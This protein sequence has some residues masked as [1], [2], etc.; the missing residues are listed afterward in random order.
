M[1]SE[2]H[3]P[4]WA[5]SE[6]LLR[7]Y[8]AAGEVKTPHLPRSSQPYALVA[9]MTVEGEL[10]ERKFRITQSEVRRG[11]LNDY[12]GAEGVQGQ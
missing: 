4:R 11:G 7:P 10:L 2:I 3:L 1:D 5:A 9:A 8:S 12:E 6:Y